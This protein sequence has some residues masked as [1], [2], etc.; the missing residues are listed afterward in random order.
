MITNKNVV[1]WFFE[2][3]K[4]TLYFIL[5]YAI[6]QLPDY[7]VSI[8]KYLK[9]KQSDSSQQRNNDMKIVEPYAERSLSERVDTL[10]STLNEVLR[11]I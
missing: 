1:Y 6:I 9:K 2:Y 5:G 7:M 3:S 4:L 8:F 11:K 10:E